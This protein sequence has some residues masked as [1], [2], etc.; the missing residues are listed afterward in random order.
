M[1]MHLRRAFHEAGHAYAAYHYNVGI[2]HVSLT[3]PA[4]GALYSRFQRI[5]SYCRLVPGFPANLV[6]LE[7]FI[8]FLLAGSV[9]EM[10]AIE[11]HFQL[12]PQSTTQRNDQL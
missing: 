2:E 6:K 11:R 8:I 12:T 7:Q 1:P 9:A 10:L 3:A 4:A 5:E